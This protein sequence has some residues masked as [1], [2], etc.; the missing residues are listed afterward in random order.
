MTLLIRG[1]LAECSMQSS[2]A[3][4]GAGLHTK[5]PSLIVAEHLRAAAAAAIGV[6]KG[7]A[8]HALGADVIEVPLV[9]PSTLRGLKV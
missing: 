4:R 8:A 2:A 3:D 7:G 6:G 1:S 5:E 9:A